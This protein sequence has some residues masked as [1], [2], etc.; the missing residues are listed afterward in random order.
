[1]ARR[2]GRKQLVDSD[3]PYSF[4]TE[5][6][7]ADLKRLTDFAPAELNELYKRF[8]PHI[9]RD[10]RATTEAFKPEMR[11]SDIDSLSTEPAISVHPLIRRVLLNF[12]QDKSVKHAAAAY[13]FVRALRCDSRSLQ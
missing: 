8:Q 7:Q 1:M 13:H 6:E 2:R 9:L 3:D 12:N 10:E 5:R 11:I 4:L